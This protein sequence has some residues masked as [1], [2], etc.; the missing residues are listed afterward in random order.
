[1]SAAGRRHMGRVAALPC[2]C[3]GRAGPSEV[4]HILEGRTPGRRSDDWLTIPLDADCHRGPLNGIHGQ[5]R[6]WAALKKDE[7]GCLAET[8]ERLYG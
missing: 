7:L 8:L 1:M 4:H 6:M 3:C 5:R 2:A